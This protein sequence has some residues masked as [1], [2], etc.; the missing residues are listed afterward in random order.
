MRCNRQRPIIECRVH[1]A[2]LETAPGCLTD[3][4]GKQRHILTQVAADHEQTVQFSDVGQGH[5]E[6]RR[7]AAL[8][9]GTK[10]ALAQSEIDVA[11]IQLL[12]QL[13][14]QIQLFQ[15]GMRRTGQ[16]Q[17]IGAMVG[18]H[19]LEQTG[20]N[21]QRLLPAD[22]NPLPVTLDARHREPVGGIKTKIRKA[23]LVRQPAFVDGLVLERQHAQHLVVLGLH[24]EVAAQ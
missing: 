4:L 16:T 11:A 18:N 8:R 6:P 12:A 13:L 1:H 23:I 15:R 20:R 3:P 10:I 14:E 2:D 22:I 7:T 17:R 5:A 21:V 24:D 9:I 19:A